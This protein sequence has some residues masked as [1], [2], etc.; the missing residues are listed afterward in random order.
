[1]TNS[2]SRTRSHLFIGRLLAG[3]LVTACFAPAAR[4]D[5]WSFWPFNKEEKP[6]KP[7][8]V[9]VYWTETVLS[10]ANQ[11]P[12]RGFGGRL[13]F[14]ENKSEDP[15]KVDGAL[16]VYAFD[17]TNRDNNNTRPDRKYVITP[18]QLPAHYSKSKLGHSYSVWVPWDEAGGV[19]KEITLIVRF[20]PK[21]KDAQTAVSDPCRE[22]LPGRVDTARVQP[23]A[24]G[25]L[26]QNGQMAAMQAAMNNLNNGM[27]GTPPVMNGGVQAAAYQTPINDGSASLPDHRLSATT[28]D[29]PS[30][31]GIRATL[32]SPQAPAA[33][34]PYQTAPAAAGYGYQPQGSQ[35]GPAPSAMA[36]PASAFP[37]PASAF[38][39]WQPQAGSAPGQ[40]PAPNAQPAQQ[41]RGRGQSQQYPAGSPYGPASQSGQAFA[42][43]NAA[44]AMTQ[45]GLR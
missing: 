8:K 29:V 7:D 16:V 30:G 39:D 18:E 35:Q 27:V 38:P 45:G 23:P 44:P 12:I 41:G 40:Q 43:A 13:M 19:Q 28:I 1:M 42:P 26:F 34:A 10:Q 2:H 33:A 14:Y 5:G 3:L 31:T 20:Q 32:S 4:G 9:V 22:L 17:D 11:P 25:P 21:A 6:G 15:V 36:R 24:G 37:A